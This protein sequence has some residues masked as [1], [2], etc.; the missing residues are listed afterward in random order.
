M[1][2]VW[3]SRDP[4]AHS[5]FC[6]SPRTLS[7]LGMHVSDVR[8]G[9]FRL[10][11]LCCCWRCRF[12]A[13]SRG[14]PVRPDWPDWPPSLSTLSRIPLSE[15]SYVVTLVPSSPPCRSRDSRRL[16]GPTVV[17]LGV[18]GEGPSQ[19]FS[20]WPSALPGSFFGYAGSSSSDP[21][22]GQPVF[23]PVW[24]CGTCRPPFSS[25]HDD[26]R[27]SPPPPSLAPSWLCL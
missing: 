20:S 27:P 13:L 23:R 10:R 18:G 19:V 7:R 1:L 17:D 21:Q 4:F 26:F 16:T 22:S 15:P 25:V 11:V 2:V 24:S 14:P 3:S 12:V 9:A 6:S 8:V 5:S